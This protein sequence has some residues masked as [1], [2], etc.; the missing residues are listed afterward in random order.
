MAALADMLRL[1]DRQRGQTVLALRKA[2][3]IIEDIDYEVAGDPA[4]TRR[5]RTSLRRAEHPV[6]LATARIDRAGQ[7]TLFGDKERLNGSN[8]RDRLNAAIGYSGFP[9]G[10]DGVLRHVRDLGRQPDA[11]RGG[12]S[13]GAAGLPTLAVRAAELE[14]RKLPRFPDAGA[15]IDYAGGPGA[16]PQVSLVDVRD[17]TVPASRFEDRIVIVGDTRLDGPDVHPSPADGGTRMSGP[18]IHANAIATVGRG[19]PL[20][21]APR[22]AAVL[23]ILALAIAPAALAL[24]SR[25]AVGV[26][27]ASAI[28]VVALAGTQL[29]FDGGWILPVVAPLLALA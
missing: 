14:R 8:S 19:L 28:G 20:R 4:A 25:T 5:L 13:T 6:V 17:G 26:G 2:C 1:A 24:Y 15:W 12:D 9:L 21:D 23:L 22:W 7:T 16:Y 11:V 3:A 29:A 18:E 27:L 10:P